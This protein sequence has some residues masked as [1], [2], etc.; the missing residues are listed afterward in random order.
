[1]QQQ[2]AAVLQV[3]RL[4]NFLA[5]AANRT[6]HHAA[7]HDDLWQCRLVRG[8]RERFV[9]LVATFPRFAAEPLDADGARADQSS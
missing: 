1:M 2:L 4:H 8:T 3:V 9:P 6:L 7:T 5:A